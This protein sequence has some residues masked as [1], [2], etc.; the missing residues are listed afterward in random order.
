M[1]KSAFQEKAGLWDQTPVE[2]QEWKSCWMSLLWRLNHQLHATCWLLLRFQGSWTFEIRFEFQMLI[3]SCHK[4]KAPPGASSCPSKKDTTGSC[5]L[6]D[7]EEGLQGKF[8]GAAR[9]NRQ[10]CRSAT[11]FR[12]FP[13]ATQ[14]KP[15][16]FFQGVGSPPLS[17]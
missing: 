8:D 13:E 9:R 3:Y 2:F 15:D 4:S 5:W 12:A 1:P 17:W 14:P 6:M 16:D 11:H 7:A 10:H